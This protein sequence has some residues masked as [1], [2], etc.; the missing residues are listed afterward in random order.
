MKKKGNAATVR[1]GGEF[2]SLISFILPFHSEDLWELKLK[3]RY[4]QT[5]KR[6]ARNMKCNEQ[7]FH[8]WRCRCRGVCWSWKYLCTLDIHKNSLETKWCDRMRL[9]D[10]KLVFEYI[11][12][13]ILLFPSSQSSSLR[14][15]INDST[16]YTLLHRHQI[17]GGLHPNVLISFNRFSDEIQLHFSFST[18]YSDS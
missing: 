13:F 6:Q 10:G 2:H 7:R 17:S 15:I 4:Y 8:R 9:K 1:T 11:F 3:R 14:S 18:F 5:Q 16:H 12:L